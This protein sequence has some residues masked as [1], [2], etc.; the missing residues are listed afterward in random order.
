MFNYTKICVPYESQKYLAELILHF[1]DI[2]PVSILPIKKN[3]VVLSYFPQPIPSF[4]I[5]LYS[6]HS[7][8]ISILGFIMIVGAIIRKE[9]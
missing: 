4:Y 7:I 9:R 3:Q 1:K 5:K 2:K 6:L 8:S